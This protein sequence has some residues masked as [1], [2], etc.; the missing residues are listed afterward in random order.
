[1]T[2]TRLLPAFALAATAL[3]P[4]A[5][6]AT[7]ITFNWEAK[8]TA[9]NATYGVKVGDV[10]TGSITYDKSLA[11]KANGMGTTAGYQYWDSP[12]MNVMANIGTFHGTFAAQAMIVNDFSMWGGDEFIFRAYGS[13]V[14]NFD[15]TF[16]DSTMGVLNNLELPTT[17]DF[18]KFNRTYL[19]I[20]SYAQ[21]SN[22]LTLSLPSAVPEPATQALFGLGLVG[23]VAARRRKKA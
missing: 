21:V 5:A 15:I 23:L 1:M 3:A 12:L 22:N 17:L 13:P 9:A 6:N 18:S 16:V 2:L 4:L 11:T 20:G 10:L 14:G 8:A 7:P 19:S